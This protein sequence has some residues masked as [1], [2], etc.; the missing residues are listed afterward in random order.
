MRALRV[1]GVT[2]FLASAA[3]APVPRRSP[4]KSPRNSARRTVSRSSSISIGKRCRT[5]NSSPDGTQIIFGRRWVDKMNDKWESS[6]WMMNADGSQP[7]ALVARIGRSV[8]AR[9]QAHRVHREGRAERLADLRAIDG[10]RR[11]DHAD[12]ASD[13]I[14]VGTRVVARRQVDRVHDERAGARHV[15]H[16]DAHA[17]QGR[18]V[19]G[20]AEGHHAAQLSL[21]SRRLHRRVVPA[22][23]RHPRR[24]RHAAPDHERRLESLRRRRSPADGKWLAFSSLREPERRERLP[25]VA[26]LRRERRD[27]R[28]QAA[29]APQRHERRPVSTRPTAR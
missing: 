10:R 2:L 6:I 14:A 4:R 12:L 20:A 29:H 25:Q 13:G 28:D 27:G 22:H 19:D 23:L 8:V 24:R 5:H 17:A 3:L 1:A 16:P 11:R 9:R 18:E 21:R 15:A 26:D 7:R